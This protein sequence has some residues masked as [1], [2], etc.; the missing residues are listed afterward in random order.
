M[1][2]L[3]HNHGTA[4]G[5]YL[6]RPSDQTAWRNIWEDALLKQPW[7]KTEDILSATLV[8]RC[9]GARYHLIAERLPA[10]DGWDWTMWRQGDE[11]ASSRHGYAPGAI[12]AMAAAE[13]AARHYEARAAAGSAAHT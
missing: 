10:N 11:A 7:S 1:C 3:G 6:S 4:G 9:G 8:A 5:R 2:E 12:T 13:G